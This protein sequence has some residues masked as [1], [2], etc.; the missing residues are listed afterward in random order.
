[1]GDA[2]YGLPWVLGTRALAAVKAAVPGAIAHGT[3]IIIPAADATGVIV[4]F[5]QV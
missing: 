4:S 5:Q 1:M 2:I 3:C